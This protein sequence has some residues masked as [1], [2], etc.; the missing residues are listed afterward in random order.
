MRWVGWPDLGDC[1]LGGSLVFSGV[2][3]WGLGFKAQGFA[4][5]RV[6][7]A[8]IASSLRCLPVN[9]SQSPWFWW[10]F[11]WLFERIFL[12][13]DK[14]N[15]CSFGGLLC[16]HVIY[17]FYLF[18]FLFLRFTTGFVCCELVVDTRRIYV[19]F[20]QTVRDFYWYKS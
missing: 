11:G 15:P 20:L 12:L 14:R 16:L 4:A 8:G 3:H 9:R 1:G 5:L 13:K 19:F 18:L 2:D 10:V 7:I 17:L 6:P